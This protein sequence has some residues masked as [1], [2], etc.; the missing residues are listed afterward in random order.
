MVCKKKKKLGGHLEFSGADLMQGPKSFFEGLEK[1][2]TLVQVWGWSHNQSWSKHTPHTLLT[3]HTFHT[4]T[5][6][7]PSTHT[8]THNHQTFATPCI[9]SPL[10]NWLTDTNSNPLL[11]IT[12]LQTIRPKLIGTEKNNDVIVFLLQKIKEY[13]WHYSDLPFFL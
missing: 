1:Y 9:N 5:H 10:W 3:T 8:H 4:H 13:H 7:H 2:S 12:L 6:T 11:D